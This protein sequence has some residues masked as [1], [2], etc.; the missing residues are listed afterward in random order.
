MAGVEPTLAE[1]GHPRAALGSCPAGRPERDGGD[2]PALSLPLRVALGSLHPKPM[3]RA[4]EPPEQA[5]LVP[6]GAWLPAHGVSLS[7]RH[8]EHCVGIPGR[9]RGFSGTCPEAGQGSSSVPLCRPRGASVNHLPI[10]P[11]RAQSRLGRGPV[12]VRSTRTPGSGTGQGRT[13]G[14]S[15]HSEGIPPR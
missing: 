15:L 3:R 4:R 8:Q 2:N 5:G 11:R 13:L 1:C 14:K 6:E 12:R 10:T 7:R 9:R